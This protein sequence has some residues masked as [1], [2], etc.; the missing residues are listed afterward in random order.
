MRSAIFVLFLL[1]VG[2]SLAQCDFIKIAA[3]SA[4]TVALK[5]DGTVW[6]W[7]WNHFG[8]LGDGTDINRTIPVQVVSPDG[9]GHLLDIIE[10]AGGSDHTIA[11]KSDST[12]LTWGSNEYGQLGD[13]S[14]SDSYSPVQVVG[15]S[16][17]GYLTGIIAIA[18][19][20]YHTIALK[21]DST[22]WTWGRNSSGQLGNGT[23]TNSSTPVQVV[24]SDGVGFLTGIIDI[25]GG[26]HT[27]ALKSDSTVWTW[28]S[29]IWGQLGDGTNI[30]KTT[31]VQVLNHDGVGYLTSIFAIA[32]GDSH[33]IALK[34]DGTVWTWG[35]NSSGKLG[36]GSSVFRNTPVQVVGSDGIGYLNEI[37][38]IAGGSHHTIALKTDSTMWSWGNNHCGQ[39]GDGM[40]TIW[41]SLIPPQD[42]FLTPKVLGFLPKLLQSQAEVGIQ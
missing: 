32:I 5:S 25:D 13:G 28:G 12:V 38:D 40:T 31:P 6:A 16:G 15:P 1:F 24:N 36:D 22:V 30:S 26:S 41:H 29:N 17:V 23:T 19:D 18:G 42:R 37:I 11:L 39:L 33:S 34:W 7:G 10:I 9:D 20:M 8:Q 14:T 27:I 2:L 35:S 4:H 21:S 3:G